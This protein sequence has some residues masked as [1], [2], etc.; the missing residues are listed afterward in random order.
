MPGDPGEG[1]GTG[2]PAQ[3][4]QSPQGAG[5]W[6]GERCLYALVLSNGV[7]AGRPGASRLSHTA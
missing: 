7:A 1:E 5:P 2:G 6:R 3:S 4:Q